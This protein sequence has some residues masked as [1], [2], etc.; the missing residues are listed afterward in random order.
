MT[1]TTTAA[2]FSRMWLVSCAMPWVTVTTA[3][4]ADTTTRTMTTGA[5]PVTQ[6]AFISWNKG[7]YLRVIG[8]STMTVQALAADEYIVC[9][10]HDN[11]K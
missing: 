2:S 5:A 4:G 11:G 7:S 6:A 10:R 8:F 1:T 3:M 9:R